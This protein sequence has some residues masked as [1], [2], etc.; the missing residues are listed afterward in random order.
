MICDKCTAGGA[1][2]KSGNTYI[3]IGLHALCKGCECQHKTGDGWYK[4]KA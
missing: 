2:N 1:A 4:T 3:A